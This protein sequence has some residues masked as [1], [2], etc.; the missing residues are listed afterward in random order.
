[1]C[2]LCEK[3]NPRP[4]A[5]LKCGDTYHLACLWERYLACFEFFQCLC[6]TLARSIA[7]RFRTDATV[8][9]DLPRLIAEMGLAEM[10]APQLFDRPHFE[11]GFRKLMAKDAILAAIDLQQPPVCPICLDEIPVKGICVLAV[12]S[13]CNHFLHV[14][15][16]AG[17]YSEK[18]TC[19]ICRGAVSELYHGGAWIQEAN[20]KDWADGSDTF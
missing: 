2:K 4:L 9:I 12:M 18:N 13:R 8:V 11:N 14:R 16:A 1:M 7:V 10:E 3:R 15:C 5:K 17:W 6:G 19:P 20:W